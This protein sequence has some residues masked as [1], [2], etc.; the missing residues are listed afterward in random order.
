MV[1][2]L[3]GFIHLNHKR[4]KKEKELPIKKWNVSQTSGSPNLS[5][6]TQKSTFVCVSF[7]SRELE[8][9]K[10]NKRD[11]FMCKKIY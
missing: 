8:I 4:E 7:Q 3:R 1:Q 2:P 11:N 10:G 5:G 6:L 9:L